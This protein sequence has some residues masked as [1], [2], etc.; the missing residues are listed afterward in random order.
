MTRMTP[1]PSRR[2]RRITVRSNVTPR[3]GRVAHA[4]GTLVALLAGLLGA[5]LAYGFGFDD[6]ARRAQELAAAPYRKPDTVLPKSLQGLTYD[7]Y[8]DIRYRPERMLWRNDKT[9]FEVAFFHQ[10]FYFNHPVKINEVVGRRIHPIPFDPDAFHYGAN[11]INPAELQKLGYAGFRVHYPVN[12]PKYKDEVLVFLGASYLRALGKGQRYGA[13]ARALA[14][15]TGLQSGEEFPRFVEFWLEKP[16]PKSRQLVIYGLLDSPRAAGAYRFVLKPGVDTVIEVKA[17]VFL[18]DHV[19]KLGLAPITAMFLSGE[20]QRSPTEDYRPEVHDSDGLSIQSG[21]G[22]WL[23]R[24]LV[25]PRRLLVTSF[26]LTN[27]QGFGLMQRDRAFRSYEDLEAHFEARPSVWVEPVGSWGEG[28]VELVQIP[29]PDETHDNIVAFWVPAEAPPPKAPL[30]Y[31][32]RLHWQ[33]D[34]EERPPLAWVMQT[35]RGVGYMRKPDNTIGYTVDFVG[36]AL[37]KLPSDA[38]IESVVTIDGNGA[39]VES[40]AY[41]NEVTGGWRMVLRVR[42]ID[43]KKP[44]EMRAY[45]RLNKEAISE[46]WSYIIPPN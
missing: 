35:R 1:L 44:V 26:A 34:E 4:L 2:A 41:P 6:V 16:A 29:T 18:R 30:D 45:L 33:K 7:Q 13:S 27:P 9:Q 21:T 46:T 31:E 8:R 11:A 36:P 19:S 14:I 20:N 42:R 37:R 12:T 17:R 39:I 38:K 24:P 22:E 5:G 43:D 23:W 15:D 10:G 40:L 25:N 32:Y 3:P 28:R